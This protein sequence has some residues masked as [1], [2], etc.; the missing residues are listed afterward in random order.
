MA[1]DDDGKPAPGSTVTLVPVP[2]RFGHARLYPSATADQQGH[3]RFPSVTP[4]TYKV[5]A[6]EEIDDTGHWDP[7][8][9]RPFESQGESVELDEGGHGT[10]APKRISAAAMQE[11]LRKAGQ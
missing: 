2:P 9:I 10:A 8:Y 4:G 1:Q 3:F 6:W 7:D 11:A 5:Y